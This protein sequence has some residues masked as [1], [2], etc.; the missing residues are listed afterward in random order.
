MIDR[1]GNVTLDYTY[2]A[3]RDLYSDGEIED[4]LLDIVKNNSEDCF[5]DIIVERKSWPIMYHL[6]NVRSNIVDWIGITKEDSVL[7]VGAGCGA[8]T[9][10]LADMA[11]NVTC[12]ELSQKRSLINAYRNINRD[13]INILLGNFENIEKNITEKYDYIT[14]IGVFEYG[15]LYIDD[16]QPYNTFLKKIKKHLKE[17]G[18]IVIAIENKLGLKY[19][20]GCKEDH[21]GKYFEGIEDYVNTKG[22]RTFSKNELE[23]MFKEIG[24]DKYE[25]YYPYPDYKLPKLIYS[26]NYLPK[27]GELNNNLWNFDNERI[28]SFDETKVYNMII[29]EKMFP[30]YSNSYLIILENGGV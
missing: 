30:I 15:E 14:L 26:D 5:E 19:W 4:E 22:V 27:V 21:V 20:A 7:E 11:K 24:M 28:I 10:K 12:I 1:V 3:G 18:K 6:S 25:F 29:K 9:G 8:I 13:N 17:N 16:K 2:Y 23:E